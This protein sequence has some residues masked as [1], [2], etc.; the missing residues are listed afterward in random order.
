MPVYLWWGEDDYQLEKQIIALKRRV[1]AEEWQDFNYL[2]LNAA[3]EAEVALGL[4]QAVTPPF[5][6][7]D[8]LTW[9]H[10]VPI[11]QKCSDNLLGELERTLRH[12]PAN[13][14][15]LLTST[16]KPDSRLKA[17]KLLEKYGEIE[18]FAPI[19]PWKPEAIAQAIRQQ[20][21]AIGLNL[22]P[23]AIDYLVSAVGN[24]LRRM[25]MEL[26]KLALCYGTPTKPLSQEQ[27]KEL[28]ISTAG[29]SL[30]LAQAINSG[31][32]S[33]ALRILGELLRS[34][35]AGLRICATLVGQFRTWTLV[36]LALE[37]GYK[38]D[39]ISQ[40]AELGNPKRV[41]FFKQEVQHHTAEQWLKTL[42]ILL[43]LEASLKRGAEEKT[44][45]TTA[46]VQ[47]CQCWSD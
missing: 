43:E 2:R 36:K 17:T 22:S 42:P 11:F 26:S 32:V 16:S 6:R 5:G 4:A 30:Q 31:N 29:T 33:H 8:R 18:Q 27:V 37:A 38:E 47:L 15:L 40:I 46:I 41:Y 13:S 25:D 20:A 34:N 7:G 12:L 1:V 9:L 28:V 19:P 44:A 35:E 21:T 3:S 23:P 39:N 24:D 10:N 45:L 14:H